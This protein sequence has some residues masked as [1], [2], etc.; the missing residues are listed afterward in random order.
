M[1]TVEIG[2]RIAVARI[3]QGIRSGAALAREI[4]V[5]KKTVLFWETG[6][7][8]PRYSMLEVLSKRLNVS[9][10]WILFGEQ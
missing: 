7:C 6:K 10:Q 4:G 1:D 2:K 9:Q 5:T 3:N 8:T